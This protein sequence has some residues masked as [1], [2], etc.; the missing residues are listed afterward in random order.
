MTAYT[1]VDSS[2]TYATGSFTDYASVWG[3]SLTVGGFVSVADAADGVFTAHQRLGSS[4]DPPTIVDHSEPPT[5]SST[6]FMDADTA[7]T[8]GA[9][10]GHPLIHASTQTTDHQSE[11]PGSVVGMEDY[12]FSWAYIPLKFFHEVT[13]RVYDTEGE[14]IKNARFIATPDNLGTVGSVDEDGYYSI[15]LLRVPY[16][17]FL[18]GVPAKGGYDLVWYR[19]SE[20]QRI[21]GDQDDIDLTFVPESIPT[22][23]DTS[24]DLRFK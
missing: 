4:S 11:Y 16:Q 18:L 1:G 12:I 13:G 5:A 8:A 19:S 15:Y 2:R 3:P 23:L 24:V 6:D 20:G 14:P 22:P 17:T 9:F 21:A 7:F 10:E